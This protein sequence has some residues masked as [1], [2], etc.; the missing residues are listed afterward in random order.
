MF[1]L[2]RL[3]AASVRGRCEFLN[4]WQVWYPPFLNKPFIWISGW[5][6]PS[7]ETGEICRRELSLCACIDVFWSGLHQCF[8]T[9]S[10]TEFSCTSL[11]KIISLR[12]LHLR[13]AALSLSRSLAM[14]PKRKVFTTSFKCSTARHRYRLLTLTLCV[15]HCLWEMHSYAH[16]LCVYTTIPPHWDGTDYKNPLVA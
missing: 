4:A 7:K 11:S 2:H 1:S 12:L 16:M 5:G 8:A 9:L 14:P 13:R 15:L 10:F 6:N 3:P